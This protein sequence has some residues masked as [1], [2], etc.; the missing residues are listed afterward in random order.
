MFIP[1]FITNISTDS[2]SHLKLDSHLRSV[3]QNAKKTL[4]QTR[5]HTDTD[6]RLSDQCFAGPYVYAMPCLTA[7]TDMAAAACHD[8]TLIE[9]K[10]IYVHLA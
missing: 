2:F 5:Q 7:V 3:E 6:A 1:H 8:S 10:N 4:F 9:V